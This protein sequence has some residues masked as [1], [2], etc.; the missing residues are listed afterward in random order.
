MKKNNFRKLLALALTLAMFFSI[1]PITQPVSAAKV[2]ESRAGAGKGSI[3]G[4]A[5][6]RYCGK[7]AAL[8]AGGGF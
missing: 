1:L 4:A 7:M 8:P 3:S 6:C 2:D 5:A